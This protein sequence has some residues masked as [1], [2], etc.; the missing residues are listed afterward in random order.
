MAII[1]E[2]WLQ[3]RSNLELEIESLG[4]EYGIKA[5]F[6]NRTAIASNGRQYGGVALL[7]R[8]SSVKMRNFPIINPEEYEILVTTGTVAGM[9]GKLFVFSCYMPP[10]YTQSRAGEC[11]D[12]LSDVVSEVKRQV[13]NCNILISGDFNQWPIE[14]LVD[15]HPDL[16]EVI[17]GPTRGDRSIDRTFVNFYRSVTASNTL[18]PLEDED[19]RQSDHRVAFFSATFTRRAEK[20]ITYSYRFYT[21]R[22]A[23]DFEAW[24]RRMD[25]TSVYDARDSSAKVDI[26]QA[27]LSKGLDLFFPWKTTTRRETDPPWINDAIRHFIYKRRRVYDREGRSPRWRAMQKKAKRWVRWRAKVYMESQRKAML[28]PDA[29]RCFYKNVKAY[30]SKEK[31]QNFDVR[32]LFPGQDDQSVADRL[33]DHFNSVS[34]EFT[35]LDKDLVPDPGGPPLPP[36][37]LDEVAKMLRSFRKPKS[38]VKGDVFPCL[39]SPL[40]D[41]LAEP[42]TNIYNCMSET[43]EWPSTWKREYVTAI[44]KAPHPESPNDLRNISCTQLFSKV[45]EAFLLKHISSRVGIRTNQFGGMKGASAEHFLIALWQQAMENLEDQRAASVLTSIDYSKAFNRLDFNHCVRSLSARGATSAMVNLVASF[46]SDRVMMVKVGE[47]FSAP[48]GVL[49]GVPQGSILGVFLFNL[50]IDMFETLSDDVQEYGLVKDG[51]ITPDPLCAPIPWLPS[52]VHVDPVR[53][54]HGSC[55][56][57]EQ[58]MQVLKYVDDN[59]LH[60]KVFFEDV[61]RDRHGCKNKHV[62]RTQNL[63]RRIVAEA[64]ARGMQVNHLKTKLMVIS[65]ATSYTPAAHFFAEDRSLV[66]SVEEMKILGFHLSSDP[67]MGAQV[68]AIKRKF[69]SKIWVL[70][71]LGHRGFSKPDLLRVYKSIVLPAHDYC[72]N[73]YNSVITQ[74]QADELERLQARALKAIYG[75]QFS[76]RE[77]R[78]MSGLTTLRERRNARS[79][80]FVQKC[81]GGRFKHWFPKKSYARELR[82]NGEYEEYYARCNRLRNSP[83]YF[84]RRRLNGSQ[85]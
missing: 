44:P 69:A 57:T 12:Y 80:S 51:Y 18:E 32:S 33:A 81:L 7:Y 54:K 19:G 62:Q 38:M 47:T 31:P 42:L 24:V 14:K 59:I 49:G 56:W 3:S 5:L 67:N 17:H 6:R 50:S 15:D 71:H 28:G 46:L 75:Y 34:Q 23:A 53:H 43:Q 4:D 1:T 55:F 39:V 73:V 61:K 70:R 30:Q 84:M 40:A 52:D 36:L 25:W 20:Q 41:C 45:Y 76:Y 13:E 79:D 16:R 85:E 66:E 35:G 82:V 68:A 37:T 63:F 83:L 26:F 21:E 10:N 2:T 11:L 9:S 29:A 8:G 58:L 60:E 77:L 27:A 65:G 22:G 78:E 72:S 48:R 74:Y 64:E